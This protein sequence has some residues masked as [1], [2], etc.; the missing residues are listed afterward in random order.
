MKV[1][2]YGIQ[3]PLGTYLVPDFWDLPRIFKGSSG[4]IALE[5]TYLD[6]MVLTNQH[7]RSNL[8][9]LDQ[10]VER[11]VTEQLQSFLIDASIL[12]LFQSE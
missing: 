4:E 12:D 9:F 3:F 11:A 7:S 10:V 5:K 2:S 1:S 8:P 6:L